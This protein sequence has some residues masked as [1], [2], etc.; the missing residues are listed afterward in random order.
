MVLGGIGGGVKVKSP[1]VERVFTQYPW[2]QLTV[3]RG[4]HERV[5]E[6]NRAAVFTRAYREPTVMAC[7]R[8]AEEHIA[9]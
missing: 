7:Q 9:R 5:S 2:I 1:T 6:G 4:S 3:Q 8:I